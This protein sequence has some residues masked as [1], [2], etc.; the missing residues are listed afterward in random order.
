MNADVISKLKEIDRLKK[1][2]DGLQPF[3]KT[4]W[5]YFKAYLDTELTYNSNA[6]EG[7]T[8]SLWET[9]EILDKGYVYKTTPTREILEVINHRDAL[10]YL[11]TLTSAKPPYIISTAEILNLHREILKGIKNDRAGKFRQENVYIRLKKEDASTAVKNFPEWQAV[12][13]LVTDL[14]R[15]LRDSEKNY[16]PVIL[17][18]EL[19]YRF[20]AIH[21]FIDGNGR[22]SRLLMNLI[23]LQNGYTF[24]NVAMQHRTTYINAITTADNTQDMTVFYLVVIE[25][26]KTMLELY[27]KT[28]KERI[29]WK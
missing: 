25:A 19:H 22:T 8:L 11:E 14:L 1:E 17:A 27:I 3:D 10:R 23:L 26:L 9:K 5:E 28:F 12:P 16:H 13:E 24:A 7:S 20:V 15:W 21:P 2:L 29:I 4:V 18:A 6:I